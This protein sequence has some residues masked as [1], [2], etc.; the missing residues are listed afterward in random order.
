MCLRGRHH[1]KDTGY[2][3]V[4][5]ISCF[6][7]NLICDGIGMSFGVLVPDIKKRLGT[8]TSQATFIGSLHIGLCYLIAPVNL[9]LAKALE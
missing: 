2:A 1:K 3:W 4:V 6:L 9:I 8:T 7:I 5:C